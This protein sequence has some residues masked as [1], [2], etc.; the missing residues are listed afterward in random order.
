MENEEEKKDGSDS[1][2]LNLILIAILVVSILDFI[3]NLIR[4]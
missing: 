4:G 2:R 3:T 1:K